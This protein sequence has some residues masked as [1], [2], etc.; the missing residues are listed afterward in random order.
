MVDKTKLIK[1]IIILSVL[2]I[3]FSCVDE[4]IYPPIRES[5]LDEMNY[6][7]D[8]D[9][10]KYYTV[11]IGEQEWMIENLRTTHYADG[12]SVEWLVYDD[13]GS[14]KE[15]YGL[16]YDFQAVIREYNAFIYDPPSK[17]QGICP[18][19]W[20]V[21]DNEEWQNLVT[22]LKKYN[23]KGEI[24][25]GGKADSD[26]FYNLDSKSYYWSSSYEYGGWRNIWE[27]EK[28]YSSIRNKVES[29]DVGW[30]SVR[31]VKD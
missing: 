12:V 27:F 11:K 1:S 14:Y 31:C 6:I 15:K 23:F 17:F 13:N 25:L 5:S 2:N 28:N 24:L 29:Y 18:D 22:N 26:G 19:G 20:H 10:N 7:Y 30:N 16:L 3:I 8:Y 4:N 9:G 21:P